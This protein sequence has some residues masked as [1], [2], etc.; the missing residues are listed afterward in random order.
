MKKLN[1]P[2]ALTL[3]VIQAMIPPLSTEEMAALRNDIKQNGQI[4][5]IVMD[6]DV[7]V[8]G[9]AR[10]QICNELKIT[11]ITVN[12]KD[13]ANDSTY[14]LNVNIN[15]RHLTTNQRAAIAAELANLT[16]GSNQHSAKAACSREEAAKI[17]GTSADSIDRFRK[18]K[19]KGCSEIKELVSSDGISLTTAAKLVVDFPKHED[20][21]KAI[22]FG[23]ARM[24]KEKY[25]KEVVDS[26]R[27]KAQE[28]AK[29]NE[30]A[31]ETLKGVY[32]VIY[33]DPPFNYGGSA[34]VKGSYCD[35]SA[36]Y[37]LMSVAKIKALPVKDCLAEDADLYLWVPSYHLKDGFEIMEAWGFEYVSQMVWVKDN[38]MCANGP[39]KMAHETLLIGRKGKAFHDPKKSMRSW[40]H[41]PRTEHSKKPEVFAKMID[42]MYPK[43]PKLEMFAREPRSKDWS[44]F[45]NQVVDLSKAKL[46]EEASFRVA[47]NDPVEKIAA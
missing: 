11:P 47:A 26:K 8:D 20:Q 23:F 24:K 6:G 29:N 41:L 37:P 44:V 33:A 28:L 34:K 16:L 14:S 21:Q 46:V 5:P 39:T 17:M 31:L 4:V 30:A 18:V 42:K 3:S 19:E 36:H 27:A 45:G 13:A 15:R 40:V 9:R 12:I 35:P 38:M 32:S 7:V 25:K 10:L 1:K 22:E 2:S 43:F